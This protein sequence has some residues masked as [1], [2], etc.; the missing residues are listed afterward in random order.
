VA[1]GG[2]IEPGAHAR[3]PLHHAEHNAITDQ[4]AQL[5]A[6]MPQIVSASF[7]T[8][9]PCDCAMCWWIRSALAILR[10]VAHG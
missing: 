9:P 8:Q 5:L 7:T 2:R 1:E 10:E 6:D 3:D 4:A